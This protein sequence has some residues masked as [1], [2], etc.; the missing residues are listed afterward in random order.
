ML[1]SGLC[2]Q[3]AHIVNICIKIRLNLKNKIIIGILQFHHLLKMEASLP[4]IEMDCSHKELNISWI[5]DT[6]EH[7]ASSTFFTYWWI[8]IITNAE[9]ANLHE[10]IVQNGRSIFRV[11]SGTV[12][13]SLLISRDPALYIQIWISRRNT[14]PKMPLTPSP[15]RCRGSPI[16]WWTRS[17][18]TP[19]SLPWNPPVLP[20]LWLP[21]FSRNSRVSFR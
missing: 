1:S 2:R 11:I 21:L 19:T 4:P 12:K 9:D 7:K 13:K 14:P 5:F 18:E 20:P 3:W 8:F 10:Y 17:E 6:A 15:W 16:P